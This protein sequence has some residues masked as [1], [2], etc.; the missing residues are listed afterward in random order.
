[1]TTYSISPTSPSISENAGSETFTVTRSNTSQSATVY[2]STV[3]DQG[4][5]NTNNEFYNGLS[6]DQITFAAGQAS[7]Q[8][9]LT[10]NDAHL[11]SGRETFRLIVQQNPTDPVTTSLA[12]DN[13]TILNN[14]VAPTTYSISPTSPSISENAGSET[15]TVTRSNTSQSATV[16]VSTVQDQGSSNTNNEF[17]NGLS[18]D[19]ITFA[20]GQAS[21]QVPL[22]INDA[23]LTSGRETFRLIVQQNPTDPVTTSLASDNFTILNNDVAPTTY[24]ISPTSPSISENAGSETFTVTRSNTSQSA[25][26]YVS[27]VQDQGSSNTNNEFYNGLSNDQI[28]FAAGQ[29]SVQVPLTINDAHLTSGRETFRLIVQQNPTD[30]VTT[31]LASDNFTILNNDVAPTTYSISP[32]SPSI[33]ENAGSETFTVTRSNTSQSATVYVSTVQDQG[34]S[35]TNNEFYNGLSNDQ[36]TFAAGQASVQ[37]PLTIND[38]H[39][40]SGSETFRL[41]V[42]QNPTDPVTTS[43]ASDNF[44]ILNNDV[45]PTTYS[46]SPTSPSI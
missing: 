32:T 46:I 28:T 41:I 5:S 45:A 29:A 24:S 42:Q 16:Y 30:P 38:A 22:T 12:S 6:N 27:T 20:A 19:Q 10:I 17:Y 31:S 26:V 37:V 2:V 1:M 9:P 14:D 23:H 4:S 33:S 11:T 43:L 13:F 15:F 25:T 18:N 34:S 7:V 44:T 3:Q 35:N 8:V 39:L 40:T 21:V 36:I